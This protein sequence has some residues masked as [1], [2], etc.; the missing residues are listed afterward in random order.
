MIINLLLA[1]KRVEFF[2]LKFSKRD[3]KLAIIGH[4]SPR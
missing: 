3:K 2:T 1:L 4:F